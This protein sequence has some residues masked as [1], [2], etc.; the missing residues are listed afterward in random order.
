MVLES[1]LSFELINKR[2][3]ALVLL[4]RLFRAL[5]FHPVVIYYR[6]HVLFLSTPT[7]LRP[8]PVLLP[9]PRGPFQLEQMALDHSYIVLDL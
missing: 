9:R 6:V 3:L 8:L 1:G 2:D 5:A 4:K 7:R